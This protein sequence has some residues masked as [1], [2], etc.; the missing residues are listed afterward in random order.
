MPAAVGRQAPVDD[1]FGATNDPNLTNDSNTATTTVLAAPILDIDG[2]GSC[3]ALTDGLLV[4][5][6]LFGLRGAALIQGAV[7]AGA[8]RT[9]ATVVEAYIQSLMPQWRTSGST[10]SAGPSPDRTSIAGF[11]PSACPG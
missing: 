7:G 2:N 3:D 9:S 6:Y 10:R 1:C 8:Q 4:I 5:R 11:P